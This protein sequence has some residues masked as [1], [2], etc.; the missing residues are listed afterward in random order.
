[1]SLSERYF[2][3]FR[4]FGPAWFE[5]WPWPEIMF[6]AQ[7]VLPWLSGWDR[8][9]ETLFGYGNVE[10]KFS[11]TVRLL[12]VELDQAL[13]MDQ[14]VSSVVSSCNLHIRTVRHICPR[15][16]FDAAKSV[17]V[18]IVGARLDYCISLLHGTSQRNFDRLQRVQKSL[19]RV[20][21]QAPRRSSATDL[22]RQLHW[23]P[24]RHHVSF[25]LG[26]ITKNVPPLSCYNFDAHEWVLIFLAE[27]LPIK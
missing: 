6:L 16:T 24:I 13:S 27:M 22:R 1:L 20:V 10:A 17:A 18:S 2:H 3:P 4:S 7:L 14:H 26:T 12:G 11:D 21:T 9:L 8:K 15:L 19:A 5:N 23:L 25:K